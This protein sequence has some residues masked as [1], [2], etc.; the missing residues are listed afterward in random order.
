MPQVLT[1]KPRGNFAIQRIYNA[2]GA[3]PA[4]G[5]SIVFIDVKVSEP[6]LMSP[7]IFGSP[8]KKERASTELQT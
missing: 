5:D 2:A 7:F 1:K 6:L 8:E 3:I 4:V